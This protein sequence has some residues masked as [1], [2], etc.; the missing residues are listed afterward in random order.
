MCIKQNQLECMSL[1]MT[2]KKKKNMKYGGYNIITLKAGCKASIQVFI[3]FSDIKIEEKTNLKYTNIN[4]N[5]RDLLKIGK[6]EEAELLEMIR[7]EGMIGNQPTKI[8]DM[9]KKY[10]LRKFQKHNRITSMTFGST[11][12]IIVIAIITIVAVMIRRR[13]IR[14]RYTN[15]EEISTMDK[16]YLHC[17]ADSGQNAW[18]I[19]IYI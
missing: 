8:T 18:G 17:F 9:K 13:C 14:N 16:L 5:L 1:A 7:Q 6:Q 3:F 2:N 10:N 12:S 15:I 11:S 19:S 4:I